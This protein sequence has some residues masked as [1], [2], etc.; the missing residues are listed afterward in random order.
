MPVRSLLLY[1]DFYLPSR[2]QDFRGESYIVVEAD[3]RPLA[4]KPLWWSVQ[5]T[6]SSLAVL[7]SPPTDAVIPQTRPLLEEPA[8]AYYD[9]PL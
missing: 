8:G 3:R 9:A 1:L 7:G 5:G 2:K 6:R 4:I